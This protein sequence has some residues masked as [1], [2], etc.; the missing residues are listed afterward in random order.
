MSDAN[1][2]PADHYCGYNWT[3]IRHEDGT[4][5]QVC[6]ICNRDAGQPK[7]AGYGGAP[8]SPCCAT[9]WVAVMPERPVFW[10]KAA[11]R[12]WFE[13]YVGEMLGYISPE[14]WAK[15]V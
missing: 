6:G 14:V 4:L 1:A 11:E 10:S 13:K 8:G 7:L 2:T 5:H 9:D 3:F 15:A 12:G